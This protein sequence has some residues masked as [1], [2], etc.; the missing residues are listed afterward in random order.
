MA[1]AYDSYLTW[2]DKPLAAL[3]KAWNETPSS[4]PLKEKLAEQIAALR[5][6]DHRWAVSSV[7]TS[8]A[9][10]WAEDIQHRVRPDAKKA[11]ISIEDYVAEKASPEMLLESLAAASDKIQAGFGTWKTP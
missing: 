4:N 11:D 8:L 7:P 9:V 6:W 5:G 3:I 1:A 10:F 2:F